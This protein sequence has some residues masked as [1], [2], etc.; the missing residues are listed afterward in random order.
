MHDRYNPWPK[1]RCPGNPRR[2]RCQAASDRP[3]RQ[4][5]GRTRHR[6]TGWLASAQRTQ[7]QAF[8]RR[9]KAREESWWSIRWAALRPARS[10]RR[11]NSP[12]ARKV[13]RPAKNP[14]TLDWHQRTDVQMAEPLR[15]RR[16]KSATLPWFHRARQM[17]RRDALQAS[18]PSGP[19]RTW[20][21]R[22]SREWRRATVRPDS[23]LPGARLN[24]PHRRGPAFPRCA[25]RDLPCKSHAPK[26][27][28][29]HQALPTIPC[30]AG[31]TPVET[32]AC[33]GH[34]SVTVY[35]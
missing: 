22:A 10:V 16:L 8:L 28:L 23:A 11:H 27:C 20:S 7:R 17:H 13:A 30:V 19:L 31:K 25:R 29:S 9:R 24:R 1:N 6:Q 14:Q 32:V 15:R 3:P 35:G 34:V 21:P 2:V 4:P 18:R 12:P 5:G 33:P 26:F